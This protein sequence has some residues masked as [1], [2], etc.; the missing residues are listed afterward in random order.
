MG[1]GKN[2]AKEQTRW[3]V[4]EDIA[5]FDKSGIPSLDFE[6]SFTLFD[7]SSYSKSFEIIIIILAYFII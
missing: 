3:K 5:L 6:F 1:H 4:D 2:I 7:Y